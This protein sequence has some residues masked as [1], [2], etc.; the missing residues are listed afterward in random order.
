MLNKI[1]LFH[2]YQDFELHFKAYSQ[3]ATASKCLFK[4]I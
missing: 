3:Q 1:K 2:I 4:E